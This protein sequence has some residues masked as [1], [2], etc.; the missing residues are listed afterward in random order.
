MARQVLALAVALVVG[1]AAS[2]YAVTDI[3]QD[4][5]ITTSLRGKVLKVEPG[6]VDIEKSPGVQTHILVGKNTRREDGYMPQAGDW[7]QAEVMRDRTAKK[8]RRAQTSGY[9]ME[10]T[11]LRIEG[12]EYVIQDSGDGKEMRLRITKE[13]ALDPTIKRGQAI[14]VEYTPQGQAL[15]IKAAPM[16]YPKLG[17]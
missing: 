16:T 1:L 15:V 12:T 4:E 10:G 2:A 14:D 9:T 5:P 17:G 8:I 13:T 3:G 6:R 7:I 11:L